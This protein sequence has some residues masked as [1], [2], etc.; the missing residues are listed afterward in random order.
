[1]AGSEL[2]LSVSKLN[3]YANSVLSN[4][5]RLRSI[6]VTGEISGFKLHASSGHLY[7]VLK[8][9][10]ARINCIMF[11]SNASKLKL[12]P[13]DGLKVVVSG[14][15]SIYPRD[16][17]YQL[18]AT[19]MREAGEGALY[20]QFL[21]LKEK[22]DAEGLFDRKRTIPFL[23]KCVG[24]VTSE[25]GAALQDIKTVIRRR[26][27]SMDMLFAHASVQGGDAPK[28]LIDAIELLNETGIPDVIIVGR[29]GGS[30][31]DLA[32]FNDEGLA[33][34][35]HGSRIPIVSAVG[36]EID[37]TIAD[38]AADLR[39]ATPS[40]AAEICVPDLSQLIRSVDMLKQRM[41]NLVN[42][43]LRDAERRVMLCTN[44]SAFTAP[45]S[46]IDARRNR[47]DAICA[48]L[49][50]TCTNAMQSARLNLDAFSAQL[51]VLSPVSILERGYA[52]V[53]N[54]DGYLVTNI[55]QVEKDSALKLTIAGGA[56]RVT[57]NDVHNQNELN[58]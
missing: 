50:N 14:S 30:Y 31:E 18:Y 12:S 7:F 3:E 13:R 9:E 4:D 15:V 43:A 28:E 46:L 1:M 51:K 11:R 54:E 58:T 21:E 10:N 20:N 56:A 33:R 39:A 19:S 44:S 52:I 24:I 49:K 48:D 35:I 22:L 16:G 42:T 5:V 41:E 57:V 36:H 6:R 26:F 38:F 34:A 32:C 45:K 40:A 47:L 53:Q 8:D 29:G 17:Q 2:I 23:P 55:T 25:T 37:F 27:P